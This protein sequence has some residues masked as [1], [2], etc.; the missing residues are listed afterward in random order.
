[1]PSKRK[2]KASAPSRNN[3]PQS[4]PAHK[5]KKLSDL[6][7]EEFLSY[8]LDSDIEE[9]IQDDVD[10]EEK[11]SDASA[12]GKTSKHKMQLQRLQENDPEF[13][14]Y[15]KDNDQN[16]PD[17]PSSSK[18]WPQFKSSIKSYLSDLLQLL[19]HISDPKI[20]C[21]ILRSFKSIFR[22]CGCF[23]KL[24]RQYMKHLMHLWSSS[25]QEDVRVLAFL[26]IRKLMDLLTSKE[27]N[28]TI[29]LMY[30]A[31]IRNCKFTTPTTLPFIAF[32]Q[33]CL[34]E[35]YNIDSSVTYQHAFIYV[36]QMAIHLRNAMTLKKKDAFQTVYNWQYL[37][38]IHLWCRILSDISCR[39]ALKP[40]IYP[41]VQT[42]L[43]VI[44][45]VPTPRFYPLRFHCIRSL[46]YLARS[47]K[48]YIPVSSYLLEILDTTELTKKRMK[49]SSGKPIDFVYALSMPKSKLAT[50]QFYD[51]T[52]E[53][54]FE[55][56][57]DHYAAHS[58]SVAFPELVY[59]A[60]RTLRQFLKT[61]SFSHYR[62][63]MKQLVDK[64]EETSKIID[65]KRSI[66]TFGPKDDQQIQRWESA[67]MSTVSPIEKYYK[68]WI[69]AKADRMK[70]NLENA[71][72]EV[73]ENRSKNSRPSK[74]AKRKNNKKA[75][76]GQVDKKI[77]KREKDEKDMSDGSEASVDVDD[78]VVDLEFSE[79]SSD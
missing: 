43:G 35:V 19:K 44:R 26:C 79:D 17:L 59:L 47:A 5:R 73:S 70:Q 1:M 61:S 76:Q 10:H 14:N 20:L 2:S 18:K 40:L 22:Y 66:V 49:E 9:D 67:L 65:S 46:N 21:G 30:T 42:T 34:L 58:Y 3:Q 51:A 77:E 38:C 63:L 31:Y 25:T 75:N 72:D 28:E 12:S 15:L 78:E 6:K 24:C 39:E 37:H 56:L 29:K 32:M 16:L 55:L 69:T 53:N 41:L 54:I 60:I 68:T 45:L 52:V 64:I 23:P 11:K 27:F 4:L 48:T 8:G 7:T 50:K 36:R 71:K 33:S 13:Y 57:L 74:N 62:R